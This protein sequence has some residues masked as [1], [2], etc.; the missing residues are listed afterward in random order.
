MDD[1]LIRL[2]PVEVAAGL[3]E[4]AEEV[5]NVVLGA[6]VQDLEV[7][8]ELHGGVSTE[9]NR[10]S[11]ANWKYNIGGKEDNVLPQ[12][13]TKRRRSVGGT[14]ADVLVVVHLS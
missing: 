4:L 5:V 13:G 3:V 6:L 11:K 1:D 12:T 7:G 14:L 2:R 9:K 8:G 10:W